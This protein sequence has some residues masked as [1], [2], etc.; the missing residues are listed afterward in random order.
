VYLAFIV[1]VAA[2]V[3]IWRSRRRRRRRRRRSSSSSSSR[4]SITVFLVPAEWITSTYYVCLMWLVR[5]NIV[6]YMD[7]LQ[8]R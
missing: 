2:V 7:W 8:Q 5:K 1:V 4:S 3:G 6:T